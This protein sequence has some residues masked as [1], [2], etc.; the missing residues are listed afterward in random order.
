MTLAL[1]AAGIWAAGRVS[2]AS[3]T[4]DPSY[5]VIDEVVGTLLAM[6]LA[7]PT[8]LAGE[9]AAFVLFRV[10]DIKKPWIIDSV[11]RLRP[12]GVGIMADDVLA[13]LGAGL[14]VRAGA[15]LAG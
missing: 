15:L 9:A 8:G 3:E 14:L 5:V 13:G 4:E 1:T 6:G 11:Q 10:L 2:E 12:A 7:R